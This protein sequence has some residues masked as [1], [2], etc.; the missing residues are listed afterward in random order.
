[1]STWTAVRL[2]AAWHQRFLWR[3]SHMTHVSLSGAFISAGARLA[4][5]V[6]REQQNGVRMAGG[7][8]LTHNNAAGLRPSLSDCFLWWG[9][10]KKKS[11]KTKVKQYKE[12]GRSGTEAGGADQTFHPPAE[13]KDRREPHCFHHIRNP[14]E[15]KSRRIKSDWKSEALLWLSR[16]RVTHAAQQACFLLTSAA[17]LVLL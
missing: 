10:K 5:A 3:L 6:W 17:M 9:K 11:R 4:L 14:K 1:M 15:P 8:R 12:V 13:V 7:K 2:N 16:A